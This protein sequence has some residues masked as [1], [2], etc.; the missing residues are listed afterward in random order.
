M[1]N[2]KK[3]QE[4]LIYGKKYNHLASKKYIKSTTYLLEKKCEENL[5]K[6]KK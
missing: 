3:F 2:T 4:K 1:H 6:K 5:F